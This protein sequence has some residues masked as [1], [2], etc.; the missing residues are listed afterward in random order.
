V[1]KAI[2]F[3]PLEMKRCG[4]ES[5][6]SDQINFKS[7]RATTHHSAALKHAA[8]CNHIINR[9]LELTLDL[10]SYSEAIDS[11]APKTQFSLYQNNLLFGLQS[12]LL[13]HCFSWIP[14]LI[15]P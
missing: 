5:Y 6:G 15:I 11:P 1:A 8:K 4:G 3:T 10:N 9:Q 12:T 7:D 13:P 14:S 2:S